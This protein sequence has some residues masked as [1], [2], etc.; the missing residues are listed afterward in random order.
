[1]C[2]L[3]LLRPPHC[4]QEAGLGVLYVHRHRLVFG[5]FLDTLIAQ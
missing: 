2:S 4:M 5:P 3:C 1:M